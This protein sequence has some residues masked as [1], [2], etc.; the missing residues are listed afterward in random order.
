M[1]I[2]SPINAYMYTY[3]YMGIINTL[4]PQITATYTCTLYARHMYI[5]PLPT[6]VIFPAH[7]I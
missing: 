3:M 7:T 6:A 4:T 5:L 2:V 1:Y